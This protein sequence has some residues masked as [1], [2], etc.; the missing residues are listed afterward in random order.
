MVASE[1]S[2]RIAAVFTR[3]AVV[4]APV[5]VGRENVKGG[6]G[7][8]IVCNSGCA[9]VATGNPGIE[10]ALNMC[11]IAGQS[12]GCNPSHVIPMSTGVIGRRLP[13][14]KLLKG[15]EGLSGQLHRGPKADA[16]AATA[17]MTTDLKPKAAVQKARLPGATVGLGGIAKGSGM[18]APN[19]ATM[20]SIITTDCD[21]SATLLRRAL[22][23]AVNADASFNRITVDTDTSTSDTVVVLANGQ[24]GNRPIRKVGEAY[25]AFTEA[26]T[27]LC[28]D[29]AYQIIADGEGVNHVTRVRVVGAATQRGAVK[30]ARTVAD[31]P[32]VKT[33][34]HGHDPNWG[35]IAAAAGRSGAKVSPGK[36]AIRIGG[37]SVY[38]AGQPVRFDER[39]VSDRMARAEVLIDIDLGLGDGECEVLG[40]DLSREY[41][42]INADY[43]T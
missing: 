10:D 42:T 19:M 12:L 36:L 7:R 24:A 9:N 40:C 6:R 43:T 14:R 41:I 2:A 37:I 5:I 4:G 34:V 22:K 30:V 18:I 33:A 11:L 25:E 26:L 17:I 20:L 32:L 13:I 8:A 21:I 38:K 3:N 27:E 39:T 29:L 31:S 15:I 35:R 23:Q 16:D 28:Q 1:T